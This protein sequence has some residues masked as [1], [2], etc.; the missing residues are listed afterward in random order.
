MAP[1]AM[2]GGRP[3]RRRGAGAQGRR[4]P[5]A[6]DLARTAVREAP[7][8]I[9]ICRFYGTRPPEPIEANRAAC[10]Q[11]CAR[12]GDPGRDTEGRCRTCPSRGPALESLLQEIHRWSRA[13][14]HSTDVDEIEVEIEGR[15]LSV[16][17]VGM[18]GRESGEAVM[19]VQD[20]TALHSCN[21]MLANARQTNEELR[22]VL[23]S[24][25][26]EIFITDGEGKT[27]RVSATC[28]MLYGISGEEIVGRDVRD[29]ERQGIFG[30]SA[31]LKALESRSRVT[32][33]QDTRSG[34]RLVVTSQPV[35]GSDGRITR[36][37]STA[38]DITEVD[39]L[40][41]QLEE[42]EQLL[43][44]YRCRLAELRSNQVIDEGMVVRSP[45]MMDVITLAERV[46][47]VDSTVLLV[48][49]S[50]VGKEVIARA[51]HSKSPRSHGPFIKINCGAI[52]ATLLE[53]ELFGYE[54]GAFTG[55]R[56]HGKPGL[57]ELAS[58]G[59][60]LLDEIAELPLNLQVKLLH[61]LEEDTVV[62]VGGSKRVDVDVR[63]IAATN[64]DLEELVR[65]GSFRQDLYYRLKVI[66]IFIPPLKERRDDILPLAR[67]F[68]DQ[69]NRRLGVEKRFHPMVLQRLLAHDWPGNV[70]E[71]EN[72]IERLVVLTPGD[73]ITTGDLP[74]EIAGEK[75]EEASR[76]EGRGRT[77]V[78]PRAGGGRTTL[79]EAV[80]DTEE[81]LLRDA[82]ARGGS[83]RGAAA[84]LGVHQSTVVRKMK[85]YG[86]PP[87]RTPAT[88]GSTPSSLERD[89][90]DG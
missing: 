76:R 62:R 30:P 41:K 57:I 11:L 10:R 85:K 15:S 3:Q 48:G 49:A 13:G 86:I 73:E 46:A 89:R 24:S 19:I 14:E 87:L 7:C 60:L 37:I 54:G 36:V 12:S 45:K 63:F 40:R 50:G 77:P 59:T 17:V 29:L 21:R 16:R 64:R 67:Y 78:P 53:S 51:I 31:T 18:E 28:E 75:E 43:K 4:E 74:D 25:Y 90:S 5:P 83:T 20:T 79:K 32:V 82:L 61:V 66:P 38:R 2:E 47:S 1:R 8:P 65:T 6:C 56:R 34:R 69:Y 70:R 58:R 55:A 84:L 22:A 80:G 26:D 71:L 9:V 52:P 42:T 81:H 23:D 68:L 44:E 88:G 33:V 35:F 27:L 72:L 39:M